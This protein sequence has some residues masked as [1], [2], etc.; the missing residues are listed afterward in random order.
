M[1]HL[2]LMGCICWRGSGAYI[3]RPRVPRGRVYRFNKARP[4]TPRLC[5]R[6]NAIVRYTIRPFRMIYRGYRGLRG[7]PREHLLAGRDRA[8]PSRDDFGGC[9][10]LTVELSAPGFNLISGYGTAPRYTLTLRL[11]R[12]VDKSLTP[13]HRRRR[14][15]PRCVG[16]QLKRAPLPTP[17]GTTAV[18][19]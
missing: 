9:Y 6:S 19:L 11:E 1:F 16:C 14:G 4:T 18:N 12:S 3:P 2:Q 17:A 13:V 8:I 7:D 10:S 5:A 15:N